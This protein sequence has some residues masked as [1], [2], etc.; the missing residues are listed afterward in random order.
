M[1]V[2]QFLAGTNPL[3]ALVKQSSERKERAETRLRFYRDEQTEDLCEQIRDKWPDPSEFRL[4]QLN[5]VRKIIDKRAMVYKDAPFRT[6]ENWDQEEGENLYRTIGAN[7]T[8]KKANRLTKLLKTTALKVGWNGERP[9]LSIVTP[10]IL[11]AEFEDPENP[12]RLIV[13]HPGKKETETTYS[14]W[15]PFSYRLF[16]FRGAPL[17]I[18]DNSE[19]INPYGV[20]P[21]VPLFDHAPDDQFFLPGGEDLIEA[22]RAVNVA[23]VNL[24]RALEMQ[25]HGQAW[26]TGLPVDVLLSSGPNTTITLPPDGKFGFASPNTPI[27]EVLHA[28][29]FLIKQTAVANDLAANVFEIEPKAESGAAKTAESRD[30]FEARADDLDLWRIYEARLFEL[31]K[32]VTNTHV[33]G[34][35]PEDASLGIDFSEITESLDEVARLDSYQ[36][37][38]DLGIWSPVDALMADNPDIRTRDDAMELLQLRREEAAGLGAAFAGPSFESTQ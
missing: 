31:I 36:R 33:P 21:F 29:E 15:T 19:N 11:D 7:I 28:I 38:L 18:P 22:Q 34:T 14:D 4:F 10:N 25:S 8:L 6:F 1:A 24:W 20:L 9:S 26:A 5:I 3:I 16:D 2:L 32:I 27:E 35:I 23:L 30:L 12:H 17:T 13:T 37:R